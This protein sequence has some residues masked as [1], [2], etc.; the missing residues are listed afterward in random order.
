MAL[1]LVRKTD[2]YIYPYSAELA[3]R[4]DKFEP[5]NLKKLPKG[6]HLDLEAYYR[7]QALEEAKNRKKAKEIINKAIK[8]EDEGKGE[9]K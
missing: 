4:A 7:R 6:N 2:G 1:Y 9:E 8:V 3:K 5:V